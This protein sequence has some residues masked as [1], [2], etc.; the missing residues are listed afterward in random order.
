MTTTALHANEIALVT[1]NKPVLI[2]SNAVESAATAKWL[3]TDNLTTGTDRV[4]STA[5]IKQVYDRH[6][7]L[8]SQP[9]TSPTS[10]TWY[11]SFDLGASVAAYDCAII[12]GHNF[13]TIGSLT[14]CTIEIGTSATFGSVTTIATFTPGTSNK[15]LVSFFGSRYSGE[16]FV[17]L[18]MVKGS[19]IIP[20]IGEFWLGR[21]RHLPYNFDTSL[22]DL[23]TSSEVVAFRSRSGVQTNYVMSRG[24]QRRSGTLLLDDT[25]TRTGFLASDTTEE[26]TIKSFWSECNQGTKA[27]MFCALPAAAPADVQL[28]NQ[29]PE[30]DFSLV[31]PTTRRLNLDLHEAAPFV[32]LES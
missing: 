32:A 13:G 31:G 19:D 23:R 2:A 5:P 9:G 27:V 1:N 29:N 8:Q 6:L 16:Q 22:D 25:A 12:A 15:R 4:L 10:G 18:K 30:L 3:T 20:K 21:R 11:L 14:T 24:Q 26:E 7:H 17:R 28:M